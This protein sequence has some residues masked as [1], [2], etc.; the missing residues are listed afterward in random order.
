M[1]YVLITL[2][3]EVDKAEAACEALNRQYQE[4]CK[5]GKRGWAAR[6][7]LD[8]PMEAARKAFRKAEDRLSD[9]FANLDRKPVKAPI[10]QY[11]LFN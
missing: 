5:K 9:H 3:G 8:A 6:E 4:A 10:I 1:D 2:R 7:A 11:D